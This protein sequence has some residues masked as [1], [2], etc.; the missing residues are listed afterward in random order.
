MNCSNEVLQHSNLVSMSAKQTLPVD[1]EA[2]FHKLREEVLAAD[3]S[4]QLHY[5][6][7]HSTGHL[8]GGGGGGGGKRGEREGGRR[9]VKGMKET[10]TLTA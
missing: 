9:R 3:G 7:S 10:H 5:K 8:G 2:E 4:H 1:E 6:A